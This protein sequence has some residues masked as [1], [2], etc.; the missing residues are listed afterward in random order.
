[1]RLHTGDWVRV[2]GGQGTVEVLRAQDR[3]MMRVRNQRWRTWCWC[4]VRVVWTER[5]EI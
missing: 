3:I 2:N 4:D 5:R 1:M